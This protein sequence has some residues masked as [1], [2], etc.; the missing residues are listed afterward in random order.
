MV[1]KGDLLLAWAVQSGHFDGEGEDGV[2][3]FDWA[4][5]T[6]GLGGAEVPVVSEDGR[7][8]SFTYPQAFADWEIAYDVAGNSYGTPAHVVA[9]LAGMTE[10]ELIKAIETATPGAQDCRCLEHRLQ[11]HHHACQRGSHRR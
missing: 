4:G 7:S 11:H 1:D 9:E 5:E 8:I 2:K 3:Y 10:D 6:A